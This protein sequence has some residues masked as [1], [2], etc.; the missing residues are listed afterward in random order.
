M[1]Q[2]RKV[3]HRVKSKKIE[4]AA[5]LIAVV[6]AV[7]Y[8]YPRVVALQEKQQNAK[9]VAN[10]KIFSDKILERA[11]LESA[12]K[13]KFL[14]AKKPD[15]KKISTE[16]MEELG[17]SYTDTKAPLCCM[18][19]YDKKTNTIVIT[20]FDASKD[21]LTRTVVNPPSFVTYER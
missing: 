8:F 9:V 16:L 1:E 4:A 6:L 2:E 15:L 7:I 5:I 11:Q 14:K 19:E 21:V 17:D 18:V 12:D 3:E 20:G 13:K 10:C